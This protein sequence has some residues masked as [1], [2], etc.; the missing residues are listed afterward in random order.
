MRTDHFRAA[1]PLFGVVLLSA[2]LLAACTAEPA[3]ESTADRSSSEDAAAQNPPVE[4]TAATRAAPPDRVIPTQVLTPEPIRIAVEDL[5]A[6]Y[7]TESA[8][9]PPQVI[10]V[11]DSPSLRAPEGFVVNVY[12]DGLE[13]PRW[14]ALTP[15]GDVLVAESRADRLRRL[16]DTDGDGVADVDKVFADADDGLNQPF[17]MGFAGGH[18]YVANTGEV[19]RFPYS[20]QD[21]IEGEGEEITQLTP[22]GYNQHWTRNLVVSPDSQRLFVSVGSAS[23]ASPEEPPRASIQVMNLDGSGRKTYAS[24]MRNPIGMDF[25]PQTGALYAVV[26]ERDEL[27]DDLVP[28]YFTR[29]QQGAFYGWPYAYLAPQNIDP[30]LTTDG[31]QSQRPDLA[32][33]TVTPD[34]LFQ[35]HVASLGL[36]IYDAD[37]F[38]ARYRGGAFA[39]FHGSWNRDRGVGYKVVY[40]PFEDG[41]PTGG[42]EDFLTGFL[43]DA[44]AP[45]TWARPVGLL[46]MPDGSLLVADDGNGRL[47]RISYDG[48]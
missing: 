13:R 6:P 7:A 44:S 32:A 27:G 17:G 24:G 39:S 9:K 16:R 46:V 10:G 42:Y 31:G 23:N 38:P 21:Q 45:T 25:H 26:N 48:S 3:S 35:A 30:R 33:Q 8:R 19:L 2:L 41:R 18:F 29:V 22:G 40:V 34:V 43:E 37:Q 36:Q 20:G 12:A 47:Y 11:P 15:G 5:P 1:G 28:D 14:L 4:R